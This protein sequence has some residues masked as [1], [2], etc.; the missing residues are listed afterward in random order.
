[1]VQVRLWGSLAGFTDGQTHVEIEAANLRELLNGLAR[2]YPGLKPQL[3]RGVSV[4]IDG[5]IYNDSWFTPITPSSEVV[6]LRRLKG[7]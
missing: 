2:D 4:S 3:D 1:M 7:G 5:R 6:L